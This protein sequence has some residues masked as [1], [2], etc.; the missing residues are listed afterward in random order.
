MK[1]LFTIVISMIL[2]QANSMFGQA[3]SV[4]ISHHNKFPGEV[5]IPV[6]VTGF[7]NITSLT[8]SFSYDSAVLNY[9]GF[10]NFGLT[11]S[12]V[13]AT[14]I[15]PG[16]GLKQLGISW[17]APG[18]PQTVN[19]TLIEINFNYTGGYSG[20]NFNAIEVSDAN[21]EPVSVTTHNGS[22][23]PPVQVN[24]GELYNQLPASVLL[25]LGVDF[26][27][28]YS[29]VGNFQFL[30]EFDSN[31]LLINGL[32]NTA[33]SGIQ[34]TTPAPGQCLIS[35]NGSSTQFSGKLLDLSFTYKSGYSAVSF[36][37]T[38]C[39]VKKIDSTIL[40]VEYTNGS[41]DGPMVSLS[42]STLSA[43]PGEIDLCSGSLITLQVK[44]A[45]GLNFPA[46]AGNITMETTLG[47]LSAVFDHNDGTY[48]AM[49]WPDTIEG[50]ALVQARFFEN[51]FEQEA[52]IIFLPAPEIIF[53][54]IIQ[55]SND[56]GLCGANLT[57]TADFTGNPTPVFT[58]TL[59]DTLI[60]SPYFFHAGTSLVLINA[61]YGCGIITGS[62]TVQVSDT[63]PPVPPENDTVIVNCPSEAIQ[64]FAPFAIDNCSGSVQGV[65][66]NIINQP[67]S[68]IC[69][70]RRDFLFTYTDA[71]GNSSGSTYSYT[72]LP[73]TNPVLIDPEITCSTLNQTGLTCTLEE[74]EIFDATTLENEV[75]SLYQ[76]NCNNEVTALLV[77]TIAG[78]YN[79]DQ[80]WIFTY[81]FEISDICGNTVFCSIVYSG[82]NIPESIELS[83]MSID[84][85]RCY[86]ATLTIQAK[87]LTILTG[88]NVTLI[89]GHSIILLPDF[90]VNSNGYLH[91]F[92]SGNFCIHPTP[93]MAQKKNTLPEESAAGLTTF[94]TW[95]K[96]YP[97]PSYQSF[98]IDFAENQN[99]G[100]LK[101]ELFNMMGARIGAP[102]ESC[103]HLL[104]V[105]LSSYPSGIYFLK[106][107]NGRETLTFKLIK[108]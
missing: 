17:Y 50:I 44:D 93:L 87:D 74:A 92:I 76:D 106:M 36:L 70:G 48:T 77:N 100:H 78:E 49:L 69:S 95:A 75:A 43:E 5:T 98:T 54:G 107:N 64:P 83:G 21:Y 24:I 32:V 97:N 59:N 30:V 12:V 41:I 51:Y 3:A 73:T 28:V 90:S 56:E 22:I 33:L 91:A 10:Q 46:S 19:G 25:P 81:E 57:F 11:G 80:S 103:D 62:F 27:M 68:I 105:D 88:G 13:V 71:A 86:N 108:Q 15:L 18:A 53:P 89:A 20:F 102:A 14:S 6:T 35:W 26:A 94:G 39:F 2:F 38:T 45:S 67:D 58:Y 9:T 34:Y 82:S 7:A 63:E 65:L 66:L 85:L 8:I 52:Q 55:S 84:D 79:S 104:N 40:P 96:I 72:I 1:R 23:S 101:I 29:G 61:N 42:F 16:T 37:Q 4:T 31:I 47:T 99:P 60:E